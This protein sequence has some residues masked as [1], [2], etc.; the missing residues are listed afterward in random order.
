MKIGNKR[1]DDIIN[2]QY[3][4]S[5]ESEI[6]HGKYGVVY[7]GK[8]DATD[9]Y[10]AVKVISLPNRELEEQL[11]DTYGDDTEK[12]E[13]AVRR[14]AFHFENEIKAMQE[15]GKHTSRVIKM[16]DHIL[17]QDGIYFDLIIIMELAKPLKNY[18][19]QGEFTLRD[20]INIGAEVADGLQVCHDN[21]IIHR[22]IKEDNLFLDADNHVK[23]GDFGVANI[24]DSLIV[25]KTMGIGTPHYMAPELKNS[26]DG[27]YDNSV[28]IYSLGIV[29]YLMCN[30]NLPPFADT[31][32]NSQE[33]YDRRMS[34]EDIPFPRNGNYEINNIILRC[35]A[36]EPRK[37]FESANKV[38]EELRALEKELSPNELDAMIPYPKR[39]TQANDE[40]WSH[41]LTSPA[42]YEENEEKDETFFTKTIDILNAIIRRKGRDNPEGD[43]I[44]GVYG[45]VSVA[46]RELDEA[47]R[48]LAVMKKLLIG[49]IAV[50]IVTVAAAVMLYPQ[51]ATFYSNINDGGRVYVK[52]LFLPE[53]RLTEESAAYLT[54][55][56]KE[57]FFSGRDE[58]HTHTLYKANIWTGET[59][60]INK[61]DECEYDIPIGNYIYYTAYN[62]GEKLYRIKKDGTD[63][64]CLVEYA[65]RDLKNRDGSLYFKIVTT[66]TENILDVKTIK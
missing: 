29:L 40:W 50:V 28:D 49:I 2:V 19:R 36:Y 5:L 61:D 41:Y 47:E 62:D 26:D 64:K 4:I 1:V 59:T 38:A 42:S 7:L 60:V 37:R 27:D 3:G 24:S 58:E 30:N 10:K 18:L 66:G 53:R 54:F 63:K 11:R 32:S 20:I 9:K 6:G 56:G 55:D 39:E 44:R 14:M 13:E 48:K 16:Y 46:G 52:Y 12:I 8:E 65:C 57:L 23:I 17:N 22:D 21:G 51:A 43:I 45:N 33:A 15:L 35:C 34:G 25:K 31:S